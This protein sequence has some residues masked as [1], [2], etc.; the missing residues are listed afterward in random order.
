LTWTDRALI[1]ALAGVIPKAQRAQ[2]RLL[3]TP[4]TVLR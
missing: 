2:L 4:D 1:A 3:V